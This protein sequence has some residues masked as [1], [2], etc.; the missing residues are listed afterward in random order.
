MAKNM[1]DSGEFGDKK[2]MKTIP[3]VNYS[4]KK[5]IP[6]IAEKKLI[7]KKEVKLSM[8]KLKLTD[9]LNSLIGGKK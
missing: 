6:M 1:G 7:P 9:R 5:K 4:T 2:T 8:P 3:N